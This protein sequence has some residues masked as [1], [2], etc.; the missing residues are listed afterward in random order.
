MRWPSL[1][2]RYAHPGYRHPRSIRRGIDGGGDTG[3]NAGPGERRFSSRAEVCGAPVGSPR[4]CRMRIWIDARLSPAL[5]PWIEATFGVEAHAL[6][7]VGLRDS[8]DREIFK[9]AK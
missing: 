1:H 2:P 9:A 3:G 4:N 8:S 7:E 6:R 5:A